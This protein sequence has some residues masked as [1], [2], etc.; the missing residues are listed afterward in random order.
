MSKINDQIPV[1]E[2]KTVA[3]REVIGF[4]LKQLHPDVSN[5]ARLRANYFC[6]LSTFLLVAHNRAFK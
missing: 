6:R 5:E 3:I 2:I 1:P 4:D